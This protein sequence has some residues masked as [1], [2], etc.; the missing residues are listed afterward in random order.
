[1]HGYNLED[2]IKQTPRRGLFKSSLGIISYFNPSEQMKHN[3]NKSKQVVGT[4]FSDNEI[5]QHIEN[6]YLGEFDEDE[7][8]RNPRLE[9]I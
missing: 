3:I 7:I 5:L 9:K 6:V 8:I 1:M 4:V 2:Y